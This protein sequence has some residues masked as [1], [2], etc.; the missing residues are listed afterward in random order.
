MRVLEK[1]QGRKAATTLALSHRLMAVYRRE[2]DSCM[3]ARVEAFRCFSFD[4]LGQLDS[5]MVAMQHSFAWFRPACDS[6]GLMRAYVGQTSLY[7]S[8]GENHLVDSVA[9]LALV[10]WNEDWDGA[11]L[12]NSLLTNR[13]IARAGAGDLPGAL[14]GFREVLVLAQREGNDQDIDDA[15][16]NLGVLK[17]MLNELDSS[18]YFN[19]AALNAARGKGN[20]ERMARQFGNLASVAID[21][22]DARGAIVLLD[23]ALLM[24]TEEGELSLQADIRYRLSEAYQKLGEHLAANAQ[25][26]QH[27]ALK[28]SLLNLEKVLALTEMQE[29]Y[30][31]EKKE[32]AILLQAK[33]IQKQKLIK[34]GFI[35]GFA[36]VIAFAGVFLFQRNRIAREK[37]RSEELLLNILP[38]EVAE[39][40]KAKGEAEARLMDEVTVLFTDFKGFTAMSEQLGPKELVHDIHECFSAFDRIMGRY[41]IEKIK[42]IGDAYMAAGGLPTPNNTHAAD[43][44]LAA[45]E[46][47]AF[48]AEG[49][50]AKL[51]LS[52]PFF[53]IRIGVHTGPVVA[54]IVGVK[55]FAYDIWGDTVNTASRMESSGEVG[56][57]NIS[58]TTYLLVKDDPRFSFTPRGLVAAKGKGQVEMWF[59]E[60]S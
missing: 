26:K 56:R 42:T 41:G 4:Q 16:T 39:E 37:E 8:L 12:R 18:E 43:V 49:K 9:T 23:S 48:I 35:L 3:L 38:E 44:L 2:R 45:F 58:H 46:I 22:N 24:A 14:N 34:N 10:L 52:L 55:K 53:E 21:R 15:Y 5:A 33:E 19:R 20:K 47:S 32:Q 60:K 36:L 30:E 27:L 50:A 29:K 17:S 28:D 1:D 25:L 59:A 11:G 6:L 13:A 54:G 57:V 7:L 51:A 31:S 40:L